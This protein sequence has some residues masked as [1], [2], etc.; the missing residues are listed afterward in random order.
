VRRKPKVPR[1]IP[2]WEPSLSVDHEGLLNAVR[3][4]QELGDIK[5][6]YNPVFEEITDLRFLPQ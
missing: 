5:K 4:V 3:I 1:D 2:K 6:S